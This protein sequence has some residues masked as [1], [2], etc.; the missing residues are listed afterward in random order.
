[1]YFPTSGKDAE[2]LE[3]VSDLINFVMEYQKENETILMGM[4]SNCSEKS[5]ARR[6]LALRNLCQQLE[7]VKMSISHPTFHHHN[8]LSESNI[9]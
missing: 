9:D 2:F 6:I 4:D 1:M 5:S 7:L 3:C 8:G